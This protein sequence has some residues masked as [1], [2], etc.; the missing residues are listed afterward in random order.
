M[1]FHESGVMGLR[2]RAVEGVSEGVRMESVVVTEGGREERV[3]LW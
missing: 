3:Q 1:E 2:L